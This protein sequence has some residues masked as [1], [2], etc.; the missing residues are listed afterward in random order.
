[1]YFGRKHCFQRF[2][3]DFHPLRWGE[4][5]SFSAEKFLPTSAGEGTPL[6][7][8]DPVYSVHIGL[9]KVHPVQGMWSLAGHIYFKRMSITKCQ[10]QCS[11]NWAWPYSTWVETKGNRY[12]VVNYTI[13]VPQLGDGVLVQE[14]WRLIY[15]PF[16]NIPTSGKVRHNRYMSCPPIAE[17]T[18]RAIVPVNKW[19][20]EKQTIGEIS[21]IEK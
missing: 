11:T 17:I 3:S 6:T 16:Q 8:I 4:Y 1:M 12:V 13:H 7:G 2:F 19:S 14:I 18:H 10:T 5:P 15:I 20:Q 21:D 9:V